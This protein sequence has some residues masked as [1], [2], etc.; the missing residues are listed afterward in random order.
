MEH[1]P[2]EGY[3]AVG[4]LHLDVPGLLHGQEILKQSIKMH[5]DMARAVEEYTRETNHPLH[6]TPC[7]FTNLIA[8]F[9]TIYDSRSR[10]LNDL[11]AKYESGLNQLR[12]A[13]KKMAYV[14]NAMDTKSPLLVRAQG[15]AAQVLDELTRLEHDVGQ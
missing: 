12:L 5:G 1:W 7:T 3:A 15:E 6:L 4:R 8:T 9:K 10:N 2:E 14:E 13:E 11:R